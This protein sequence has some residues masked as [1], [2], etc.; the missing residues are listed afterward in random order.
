MGYEKQKAWKEIEQFL[1][2]EYH[3]TKQ[4]MPKEEYWNFKGHQI[5][6]DTYRNEKAKAKVIL[7]HG[8][9][10]NGRQM[11]TIIGHPLAKDGLEVIAMDMPMYGETIVHKKRIV[12]YDDWVNAGNEYVKYELAKDDR[13]IFLYGL[14]AGGMET[15]HVACKNQKVKGI[16][17]MTFLD[18]RE[19]IVSDATTRNVFW[20]KMGLPLAKLACFMGLS[21]F[22]MKMSI[23]S[24]M[25]ALC[26]HKQALK[27]M[28]KDK[29]SAGNKVNMK[30]LVDY[31]T[32]APEIEAEAFDVCPI[33]L[34]QPE[35]D[36]WTPQYLSDAFLN[37]ISKVSCEKTLLRKGS[38]YPIEK[39]AL[40][41]LHQSIITFI[42]KNL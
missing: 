41:D 2:K 6:L 12:T 14:S 18:Q 42:Q 26:N 30:F 28:L 27:A 5:H 20:A 19:K 16:I 4:M 8:V 15:Y 3:L 32:Y 24:K 11:T 1:P 29:T 23:C 22:P 36:K 40:E 34:T 37:K 13:P 35:N 21:A 17:G 31:M 10:T 38:H 9:G 39:E 7:F 33:L 25:N